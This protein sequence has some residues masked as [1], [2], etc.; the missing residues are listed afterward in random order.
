M[1]PQFDGIGELNTVGKRLEPNKHITVRQF[2]EHRAVLRTVGLRLRPYRTARLGLNGKYRE[3]SHVVV[4]QSSPCLE[5][6][7]F[8]EV[9]A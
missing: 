1:P 4:Q 6:L 5:G 3:S 8:R 9:R 2:P 7:P